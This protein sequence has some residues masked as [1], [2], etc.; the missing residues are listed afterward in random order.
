MSDGGQDEVTWTEVQTE[1]RGKHRRRVR[2]VIINKYEPD[3]ARMR[4]GLL[5]LLNRAT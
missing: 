2:F 1:G 3:E 4:E 5:F